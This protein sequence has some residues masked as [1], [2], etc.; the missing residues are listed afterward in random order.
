MGPQA[1]GI[2]T[3][4][5]HTG[6]D[7]DI[8]DKV[9]LNRISTHTPHTGC[10]TITVNPHDAEEDFNSHTPHGVRHRKAAEKVEDKI[11]STHTPHTGCDLT[12]PVAQSNF[13]GFQLTHPTRGA[14]PKCH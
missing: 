5:P 7:N 9:T 3:H 10:D 12:V 1:V 4:T 13:F 14:T 11:I 2:S 8:I 6:C